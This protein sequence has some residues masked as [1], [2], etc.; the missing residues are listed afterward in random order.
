MKKVWF[1]LLLL[2]L[3]SPAL[4]KES[5]EEKQARLDLACEDAREKSWHR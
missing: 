5:R 2:L 4:A 1:F 3:V